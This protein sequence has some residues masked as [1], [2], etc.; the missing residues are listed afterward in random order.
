M[1]GAGVAYWVFN[2]TDYHSHPKFVAAQSHIS[3]QLDRQ[4]ILPIKDPNAT[5]SSK[6]ILLPIP[7]IN[8]FVR[9]AK[10]NHRHTADTLQSQLVLQ[11]IKTAI[12]E[13]IQDD[14]SIIYLVRSDNFAFYHQAYQAF[15]ALKPPFKEWATIVQADR[16]A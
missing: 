5:A 1:A 9:F 2:Y 4:T 10:T 7:S 16:R 6:D 11:D 3:Q 13:Q 14:G 12:E 8:Y 15:I